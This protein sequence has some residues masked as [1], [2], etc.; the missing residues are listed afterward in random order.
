MKMLN[1]IESIL[2]NEQAP[3]VKGFY[4][5]LREFGLS[6]INSILNGFK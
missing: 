6:E 2:L 3:E 4:D 1:E 5:N